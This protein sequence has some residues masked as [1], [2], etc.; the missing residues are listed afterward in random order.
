MHWA[1]CEQETPDQTRPGR[2]AFLAFLPSMD[3]EYNNCVLS[4]PN[5]GLLPRSI[6]IFLTRV[7]GQISL[8]QN[9]FFAIVTTDAKHVKL[10]AI[11]YCTI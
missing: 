4:L 3:H 9:A 11:L 7:M 6:L 8:S 10:H 1:G 5:E 2:V